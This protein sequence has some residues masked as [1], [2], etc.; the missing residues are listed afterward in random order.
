MENFG[1]NAEISDQDFYRLSDFI[2]TNYGIKLLINKKIMLQSRLKSRLKANNMTS[3]KD[4][5]QYVLSGKCGEAEIIEMIDLVS[6]NK[7]DFYRESVHFDFLKQ[8]ALP[9]MINQM[10]MDYLK[11][12]SSASSSGEE[13]Y[14]IT[15]VV[16]EFMEKSPKFDYTV[17]GTDISSRILDK[18]KMAVYP[19]DR[20]DVIPIEQKKKYLLRSKDLEN[21]S[22]R[23][24]PELRAKTRFQR[25]NLI[26]NV[27]DV[28]KDFDFIFCRNVLIYFDRET[29]ER[30]LNKLCLHLRIGGYFFL[31]HSESISAMD[32][33][34]KQIKPTIFQKI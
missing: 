10:G 26:D 13:V 2:Y 19:M 23:I 3:F 28:A 20:I 22:V 33:P 29:Q 9:E 5:T 8:V 21:P 14:T 30:V 18:A 27:Y 34:L 7:T 6:T 16:S 25:L 11:V 17:L 1:Y 31:G 32:L 12:W 4:Y 24:V 15:M